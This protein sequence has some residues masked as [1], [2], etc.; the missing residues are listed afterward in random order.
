MTVRLHI[1]PDNLFA[2]SADILPKRVTRHRSKSKQPCSP[3]CY[4]RIKDG[5]SAIRIDMPVGDQ[6]SEGEALRDLL[7]PCGTLRVQLFNTR[8]FLLGI[9][10]DK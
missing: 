4:C 2:S 8:I 6:L 5:R 7:D 3:R 10:F 9:L 1:N